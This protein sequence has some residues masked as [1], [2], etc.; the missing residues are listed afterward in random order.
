MDRAIIQ[1]PNRL[2]QPGR[3]WKVL[4]CVATAGLSAVLLPGVTAGRATAEAVPAASCFASNKEPRSLTCRLGVEWWEHGKKSPR[5]RQA[6]HL[7]CDDNFGRQSRCS[8]ERT[9]IL[10]D[11]DPFLT[12][13]KIYNHSTADGNL[14]IRQF[15]WIN[16]RLSFD[17]TDPSGDRMSVVIRLKPI[18]PKV[19]SYL[20]IEYLH[21]AYSASG[22]WRLPE[23][24]YT[25]NVPFV[26]QG[27][28]SADA[29]ALDDIRKKLSPTDRQ[30]FERMRSAGDD[31]CFDLEAW[32][33]QE[34]LKTLL[35]PYD[36]KLKEVE[37]QKLKGVKELK[38][39]GESRT[40]SE[41]NA[42]QQRIIK[43]L[44]QKEEVKAVLHNKMRQC[45]AE[46]GMSMKGAELVTRH[47]LLRVLQ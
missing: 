25:M 28:K 12:N 26:I 7:S 42:E 33:E 43:E 14:R 17:V 2:E 27:R 4:G 16:W 47:L 18:S 11:P 13:V 10:W 29:K 46:A 22:E 31:K 1:H 9:L 44:S 38:E 15:D 35:A 5:F 3:W 8:L 36:E 24:S 23:Y 32:F 39:T 45:L 6:W 37:R 30:T 21:A 40:L 34:P 20:E 19:P 41:A